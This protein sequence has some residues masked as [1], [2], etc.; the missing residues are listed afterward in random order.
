MRT[1]EIY[2]PAMCCSTGVCG[3]SVDQRLVKLS[4]DISFLKSRG[5][6]VQ[7]FNLAHQPAAFTS[8]PVVLAEMGAEAEHLP[9][10]IVDGQVCARASYP[11]REELSRWFGI[12]PAMAPAGPRS[13]LKMATSKCCESEGESCC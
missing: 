7:R 2:D 6:I 4:A 5:V 12:E 10:F 3:P 13:E 1:L 11:D 8:N 9:L